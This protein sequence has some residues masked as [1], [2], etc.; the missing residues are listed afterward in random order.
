MLKPQDIMILLKIVAMQQREWKY[1]EAALELAMSPSEVHSGVKRLKKCMLLTEFSIDTGASV[2]K[3]HLPDTKALK[4]FMRYGLSHVFPAQ[5]TGVARGIPTSYGFANLFEGFAYDSSFIPVWE[6]Q[7]GE[8]NG[9]GLKPLYP[10]A[11]QAAVND[12]TLYEMLAL[13]DALRSGDRLLQNTAW[14]KFQTLIG[15]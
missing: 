9:V 5:L 2:Y 13:T 7:S 10:S 12:F 15:E 8:Y 6:Y 1:S 11:P 14:Q 3:R 4:E